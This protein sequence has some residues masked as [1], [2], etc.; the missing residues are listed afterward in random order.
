MFYLGAIYTTRYYSYFHLSPF[1]LGFGFAEFVM[2][3][4]HLLTFQ[5]VIGAVVLLV[6]IG[7]PGVTAHLPLPDRFTR[8]VSEACH[9]AA[10]FHLWVVAAGLGLLLLWPWTQGYGWVAPF[11]MAAGL[12]L[13]QARTTKDGKHPE[14]LR[15]R[16][17]PIF[18]A[19]VFLFWTVTLVAWQ[20]GDRDA[21]QS[22]AEVV[23]WPGVVV[24]STQSLSLPTQIV[25][26]EDL[27]EGLHLRYRYSDLRLLVERDGRYYVVPTKWN[28]RTDSVY[29]IRESGDTRIELRPGVQ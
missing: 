27:G 28:P 14:G 2:Q 12:L 13:G 1:S 10:R 3:C 22:A 24:L 9:T 6:V 26:E 21:R 19:G 20:L 7:A 8:G 29:I 15:G 18:A 5:V 23:R 11:T 25:P 4:L 16:A 17:L